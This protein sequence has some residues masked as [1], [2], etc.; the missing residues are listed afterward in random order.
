MKPTKS[1]RVWKRSVEG[2]EMFPGATAV[3]LKKLI[4]YQK[5]E[6]IQD[7]DTWDFLSVFS[8]ERKSI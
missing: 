1:W 4:M 6:G 8:L 5:I 3:Q 7:E 2:K